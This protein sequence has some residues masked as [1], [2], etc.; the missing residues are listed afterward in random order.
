MERHVKIN[1]RVSISLFL[2]ACKAIA[3]RPVLVNKPSAMFD[4]G[5][6]FV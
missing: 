3:Q 6:Y 2:I 4:P 5:F 1:T